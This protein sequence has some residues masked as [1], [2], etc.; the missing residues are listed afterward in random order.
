M[1]LTPANKRS[2]A[3]LK[4]DPL[5]PAT[6]SDRPIAASFLDR[7][8][9]RLVN[10]GL[11]L[12]VPLTFPVMLLSAPLAVPL[13]HAESAQ[14]TQPTQ[15]TPSDTD[16]VGY[17]TN[18]FDNYSRDYASDYASDYGHIE[19]QIDL[20][21]LREA[22]SEL[23]VT[24]AELQQTG[25]RYDNEL[26]EPLRLLG[27]VFHE[28]GDYP[29]A[30][31]TLAL[32][33]Q[34]SRV[35]NGLHSAD[36]LHLVHQEIRSLKAMGNIVEANRRHEYAFSIA[37]RHYG[38]FG[39]KLIPELLKIGVWYT[40]TGDVIGARDRFA[41]ARL[42]LSAR[43]ETAQSNDMLFALKGIA[44]SYRDEAFPPF[45]SRPDKETAELYAR[46]G[47]TDRQAG[48]REE[49]VTRASINSFHR[50]SEALIDVVRIE[51][52]RLA[53]IQDQLIAQSTSATSTNSEGASQPNTTQSEI[54]RE[55]IVTTSSRRR[56]TTISLE[57]LSTVISSP[58]A[59]KQPFIKSLLELGDWYL[60][61]NKESRAFG[62]YQHAYRVAVQDPNSDP[63]AL[64]G[65]PTLLYF[66]RPRDPRTPEAAPKE[67]FEQGFVELMYDVD[68]RG[69]IKRLRTL[70]SQP[71]GLMD[72]HVRSSAKVARYRPRIVEGL[73]QPSPQQTY[74]HSFDYFPRGRQ[75]TPPKVI[76]T[77]TVEGKSSGQTGSGR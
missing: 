13:V 71:K 8:L 20:G 49:L 50:G 15:S 53:D 70:Q 48:V 2:G 65:E 68:H 9:G 14:S 41:E 60:L 30:A 4:L 42:L 73:P 67:S 66:P 72:F 6:G 28:N 46:N 35:A 55:D 31:E 1:A 37:R 29:R 75:S 47:L 7:T 39:E 5:P 59:D 17:S 16:I 24:I 12:S 33:T 21:E 10:Q 34:I 45:F 32:A 57:E 22:Q 19:Q 43:P 64:F 36:Q 25:D 69:T 74:R 52:N 61:T 77:D 38:R 23:E 56:T 40:S 76:N 44:R 27:R 54:A 63:S 11:L 26:V 51:V 62:Y 3:Q 58:E 18:G